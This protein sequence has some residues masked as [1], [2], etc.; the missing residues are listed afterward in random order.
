MSRLRE[1]TRSAALVLGCVLCELSAGA[2][3][4]AA[5]LITG[6]VRSANGAAIAFRL[7]G[8]DADDLVGGEIVLGQAHFRIQRVSLRGLIGAVRSPRADNK[9]RKEFAVFSSSYSAQTATGTPW[10]ASRRYHQCDRPYNS[11]LAIY[12]VLD[13]QRLEKL[14]RSPYAT[15][16]HDASHANDSQVFCFVSKRGADR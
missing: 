13:A 12:E 14:G 4:N 2:R 6:E 9:S 11:F 16:T 8:Q 1:R 3:V 15:L 5:E 7:L 10:V